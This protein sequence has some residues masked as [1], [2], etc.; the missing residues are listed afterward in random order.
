MLS[1]HDKD[2]FG[3]VGCLTDQPRTATIRA[4]GSVE[5]IIIDGKQLMAYMEE[6]P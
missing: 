1:K 3:E 4:N 6:N 2:I 5:A